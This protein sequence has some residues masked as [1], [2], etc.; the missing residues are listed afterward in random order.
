MK[1]K[2]HTITRKLSIPPGE[3]VDLAKVKVLSPKD[4][5]E[6]TLRFQTLQA[7]NQALQKATFTKVMVEEAY[8]ARVAKTLE[9]YG[10]KGQFDIDFKTGVITPK[11]VEGNG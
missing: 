4:L 1:K 3:T 8:Q 5:Q 10:C 6:L 7:A 11:K 9:E 2:I